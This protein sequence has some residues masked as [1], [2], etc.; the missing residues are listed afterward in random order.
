MKEIDPLKTDRKRIKEFEAALADA[1]I[2]VQVGKAGV[3]RKESPVDVRE[4]GEGFVE[5]LLTLF[6]CGIEQVKEARKVQTES[7][8]VC[9]RAVK[10]V[11]LEAFAL[12]KT[13]IF[14]FICG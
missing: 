6:K 10:Q 14:R 4:G 11:E 3:F 13:G 12:E 1:H 2:A 8:A 7:R 9:R 5:M